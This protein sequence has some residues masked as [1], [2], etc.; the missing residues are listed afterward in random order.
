MKRGKVMRFKIFWLKLWGHKAKKSTQSKLIRCV[1][2]VAQNRVLWIFTHNYIG[3]GVVQK[4][5][6]PSRGITSIKRFNRNNARVMRT[7]HAEHLPLRWWKKN[8]WDTC[9]YAHV[10]GCQHCYRHFHCRARERVRATTSKGCLELHWLLKLWLMK[11]INAAYRF[12]N[13]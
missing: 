12:I 2:P 13:I 1:S 9:L 8:T 6:P 4:Y 5:T 7:G 3:G 11:H 10:T